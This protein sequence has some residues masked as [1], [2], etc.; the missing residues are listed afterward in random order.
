MTRYH[1]KTVRDEN[2]KQTG[3]ENVPFIQAEEDTQDA[4]DAATAADAPRQAALIEIRRL[5]A[6]VT[7][8]LIRDAILDI[9]HPGNG[10]QGKVRLQE[11]E[12]LIAAE[13]SKL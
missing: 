12:D 8:W 7:L 2:G 3:Q 11:L 5:E 1:T 6:T 10:K 13:R 9:A 4:I